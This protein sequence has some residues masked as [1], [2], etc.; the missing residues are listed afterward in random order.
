M[1]S[2]NARVCV[3]V[4]Y[5]LLCICRRNPST[6]MLVEQQMHTHKHI[7]PRAP[8]VPRVHYLLSMHVGN[9]VLPNDVYIVSAWE[10]LTA[11]PVHAGASR[12]FLRCSFFSFF[13]LNS[14]FA[15]HLFRKVFSTSRRNRAGPPVICILAL[16]TLI[17]RPKKF[18]ALFTHTIQ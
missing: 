10:L 12:P 7:V 13:R 2:I 6:P 18:F 9:T 5:V 4:R 16:L 11:A 17:M 3:C 8:A 15:F 14:V 1:Y